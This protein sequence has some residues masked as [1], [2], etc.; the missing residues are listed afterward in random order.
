MSQL[1]SIDT[2]NIHLAINS[3]ASSLGVYIRFSALP[4]AEVVVQVIKDLPRKQKALSSSTSTTK[5]FFLCFLK[6]GT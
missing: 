6:I 3:N 5:S 2:A 1:R 4:G